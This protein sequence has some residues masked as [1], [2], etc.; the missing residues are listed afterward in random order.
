MRQLF[1]HFL[2]VADGETVRERLRSLIE[3]H[4]RKDLVVDQAL[5]ERGRLG[6]HAVEIQRSV[7]LLADLGER[8][9]DAFRQFLS[10]S[11]FDVGH[12]VISPATTV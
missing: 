9:E 3:Q 4:H 5:D 6:Q 12:G 7:D 8:G 1:N 10:N 11:G 2:A